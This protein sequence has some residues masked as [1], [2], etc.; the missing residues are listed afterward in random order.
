[1]ELEY[2]SHDIA[3]L[4]CMVEH[5]G[6]EILLF[7]LEVLIPWL[8]S[9]VLG[10]KGLFSSQ[11]GVVFDALCL[12]AVDTLLVGFIF[13]SEFLIVEMV[14]VFECEFGV[15]PDRVV[16]GF[17]FDIDDVVP[18]VL[19]VMDVLLI[20]RERG[21]AVIRKVRVGSR[22]FCEVLR[23]LGRTMLEGLVH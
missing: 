10:H 2:E 11:N 19:L 20:E 6:S 21:V 13:G 4:V 23:F 1:M 16:I 5:F 9:V 7:L 22:F 12:T 3:D 17:G 14:L 18:R 8:D 15:L